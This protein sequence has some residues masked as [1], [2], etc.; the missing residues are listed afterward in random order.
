MRRSGDCVKLIQESVTLFWQR[1]VFRHGTPTQIPPAKRPIF[2]YHLLH[3]HP[4]LHHL[5][6]KRPTEPLWH[7]CE[8]W[9]ISGKNS[10]LTAHWIPGTESVEGNLKFQI[11]NLKS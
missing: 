6:G 11:S 2:R 9:H 7:F 3:L 8:R 5:H 1:T 10:R 4:L